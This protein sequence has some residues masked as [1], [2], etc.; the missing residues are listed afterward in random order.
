MIMRWTIPVLLATLVS[1]CAYNA[2]DQPTVIILPPSTTA[3]SIRLTGSSRPDRALD[4]TAT[5]LSSS[6]IAVPGVRVDLATSAGVLSPTSGVTDGN[7]TIKSILTTGGN[8]TVSAQAGSLVATVNV[9]G[10]PDANTPTPP[11]VPPLPP[12]T[13]TPPAL[14]VSI[15]VAGSPTAGT[16]TTF[17]LSTQALSSATWNFGDGTIAATT[18]TGAASHTYIRRGTLHGQRHRHRYE[19]THGISVDVGHRRGSSARVWVNR[20]RAWC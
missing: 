10:T 3:A 13:P 12:V 1:G 4:I 18:G 17:G 11:V 15:S 9:L 8:A 14:T 16:A 20:H 2:P 7:G 6:G 19:R 5:V